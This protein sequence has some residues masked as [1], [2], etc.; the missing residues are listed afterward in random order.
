MLLTTLQLLL[1]ATLVAWRGPLS[2]GRLVVM[3]KVCA[4]PFTTRHPLLLE[5]R[6]MLQLVVLTRLW[7]TV[8]IQKSFSGAWTYLLALRL[9]GASLGRCLRKNL[10][11]LEKFISL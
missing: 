11:I 3:V 2:L 9:L 6:R 7:S 5:T 8:A 1:S 10:G 4:L